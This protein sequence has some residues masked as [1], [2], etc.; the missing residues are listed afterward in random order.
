MRLFGRRKE[1]E[2]DEL[3]DGKVLVRITIDKQ[4]RQTRKVKVICI[5]R[6]TGRTVYKLRY[7]SEKDDIPCYYEAETA[8]KQF[9]NNHDYIIDGKIDCN[10]QL[11][12][13]GTVK[14]KK[15]R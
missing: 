11:P 4:D 15:M 10:I 12:Y 13:V 5:E 9:I 8:V 6:S 7:T 14:N 2:L 1:T 3:M